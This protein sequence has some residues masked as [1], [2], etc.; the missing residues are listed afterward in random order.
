MMGVA[1]ICYGF[2]EKNFVCHVH[3]DGSFEVT[4]KQ[5]TERAPGNLGCPADSV[6]IS[7]DYTQ[8]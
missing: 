7:A 6:L 4:F 2:C 3:N 5:Y 8:K 1:L